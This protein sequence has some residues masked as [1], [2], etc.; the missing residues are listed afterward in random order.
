MRDQRQQNNGSRNDDEGDIHDFDND[1]Q[2]ARINS[3]WRPFRLAGTIVDPVSYVY[4]SPVEMRETFL[5]SIISS[6]VSWRI[7]VIKI[8][9]RKSRYLVSSQFMFCILVLV[10]DSP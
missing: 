1:D 6:E 8:I 10:T 4:S 2:R 7:H 5:N 9:D 3:S